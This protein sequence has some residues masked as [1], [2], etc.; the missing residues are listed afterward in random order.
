MCAS[1]TL[2]SNK[3]CKKKKEKKLQ[4]ISYVDK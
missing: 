4:K 3:K 1:Q 2:E